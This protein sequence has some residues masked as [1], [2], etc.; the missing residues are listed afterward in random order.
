[1][2]LIRPQRNGP[3]QYLIHYLQEIIM[4]TFT[5]KHATVADCV[6]ESGLIAKQ[7]NTVANRIQH[8]AT[9]LIYHVQESGDWTVIFPCIESITQCN[10]VNKQALVGYFESS[11]HASI[12][13]GVLTYDKGA[14][15]S[16][17]DMDKVSAVMWYNFKQPSSKAA[18]K[19]LGELLAQFE[20]GAKKS[21]KA[22]KVSEA[23]AALVV[24]TIEGLISGDLAEA[25]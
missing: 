7:Q 13:E 4:S 18:A 8:I 24:S 12:E 17:I 19:S 5:P 6:K 10:G 1:M 16:D 22:G 3:T 11:M 15:A 9:S 20:K 21:I 14:S 25:A 23:D 2:D